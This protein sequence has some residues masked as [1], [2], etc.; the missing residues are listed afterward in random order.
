MCKLDPHG[1]VISC[2]P[3]TTQHIPLLTDGPQ[4]NLLHAALS[5]TREDGDVTQRD[6]RNILP[7]SSESD[8]TLPVR[9]DMCSTS[10]PVQML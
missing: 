8:L 7:R 4:R 1:R 10:F 3:Q 6:G 5:Q 2:Y 9:H